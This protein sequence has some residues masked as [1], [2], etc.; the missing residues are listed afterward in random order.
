MIYR[1]RILHTETWL[2]PVTIDAA[3][4]SLDA[5]RES[6]HPAYEY[7]ESDYL[8]ASAWVAAVQGRA[9]EAAN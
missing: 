7:V 6:R 9:A 5:T 1:F 2:D 8:L 3:A 4:S